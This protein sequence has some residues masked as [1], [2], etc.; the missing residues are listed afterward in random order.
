MTEKIAT[1]DLFAG[2]GG[3]SLGARDAGAELRLHLDNDPNSCATLRANRRRWKCAVVVE[4]DVEEAG[5]RAI[6]RLAD[7]PRREPLL[8]VGGAPCQPFSKAAYWIEKGAEAA[9]RRARAAGKHVERPAAPSMARP[10][11][12]RELVW[13]YWRIV[14]ETEASGFVFE[15]VPS[16][17]HPRN[18]HIVD[19]LMSAAAEAGYLTTLVR[20]NA[21]EYGVAQRRERVFVLGAQRRR[22]ELPRPTHYLPGRKTPGRRPAKTAGQAIARYAAE[23]YAEPE[24]TVSGRWADHLRSI[25]PGWNY[26]AHTAWGGHQHPT[27]V[28]ETR[29]W[30]FLLKLHPDLPSWTVSANPGPWVGPFHW[31]S[32]RLRT[33]ELAALQGFPDG[34]MFVGDRR[35]RVR[36][37]G[38]AVPPPL[39]KRMVESVINAITKQRSRPH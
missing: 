9:Y 17:L 39:A 28:T 3:L 19:S 27:F 8:I 29:F 15:N 31:E 11:D 5:G 21:A 16:I 12:R 7:I 38:N 30:S 26:K 37:I 24:E 34:Y 10:D 25:P 4:G 2:A 23:S 1:I 18:R 35:S 14:R 6:R 33:V 32:R 36:Q 22:P 20:S 13:E